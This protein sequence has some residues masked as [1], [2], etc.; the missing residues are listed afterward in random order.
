MVIVQG[1]TYDSDADEEMKEL[2]IVPFITKKMMISALSNARRSVTPA[3]L[4]KYM[5]YKRDM[6]RRLGMDDIESS[7][8]GRAVGE[9]KVVGLDKEVRP[10]RST[11]APAAAA[12]P[13]AF[14][15]EADDDD[16]I[17]D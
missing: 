14:A 4:E 10:N 2:D 7:D 3:D 11:A 12:A 16:D 15:E 8:A 5:R 17:Y 9:E 13:R 6:E 1:T